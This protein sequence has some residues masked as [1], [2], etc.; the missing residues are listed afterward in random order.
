M[1]FT[2][3]PSGTLSESLKYEEV[4]DVCSKLK[5]GISGVDVDYEHIRYAG[6][7][8]WKLLFKLYQNFFTNSSVP[9]SVL[10]GVIL[11]LFKGKSAKANNK[12]NYR[13]ITLFPTLCKIYEMMLL[14]KLE[15]FAKDKGLFS[16]MQFGFKEGVGCTE[17]SFT[18]LEAIN[19]MI[20]RGSNVF[21]CFLDV[22]KAFDT[23]WIDGLLFKLFF[24]FGIRGRMWLALRSL[25]T[26]MK[27]HVLCFGSLSRKFDILQG[28]GQGRLLAPFMYKVYIN[29]LLTELTSHSCAL[30]LNNLSLSS[31]SFADDTSLLS[32]YPSF[33]NVFMQ[34]CYNYSLK[35]RYEFNH[36]KSGVV[37]FGETRLVHCIAMKERKWILGND[38]VN[39]LYEY[40][41]LGVVKNYIGSFSSN[42]EV[43]IDK[44]RKKAGMLFSA[45]FDRCKVNPLVYVKLWRQ[46]CLPS[47]LHG[48]ELF[49]ITQT[50]L[51]KFER[52]QQWFLKHVFYVPEFAPKRLLLKLSRLNSIESEIAL[53]KLLFLGRLITGQKMT[54]AL[55]RLFEL[56]SKSLFDANIISLGVLLSIC[57][58]LHKL[59]LFLYFDE[60]FQYSIFPTY[61]PWKL[62]VNRKIKDY[63]ENAWLSFVNDHPNFQIA[64][65]CLANLS[66]EKFWAITAEYPDLVCRLH[67]Q[68]RMMGW[69]GLNGGIPWL[70]NTDGALCFVCKSDIETLD[71]FLFNCPAFRQNFEMLWSS[72]NHKIKNCNPVDADNIIQFILNLDKSS[73]TMLLLGCLPL[74]FD[75]LTVSVIIR[76]ISSALG[77]I[78]KI[79]KN[80]L[81]ELE[82]PWL[83]L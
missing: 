46:A 25:Y 12:D 71:H 83:S 53:R 1:S 50:L 52:C 11:P 41:N 76:F 38:D 24:E 65:S 10:T 29:G 44:T 64:R 79:R 15:S 5:M 49:T 39:E 27:A 32:I 33:L 48:T 67:V 45:T 75:S 81:R 47:L 82:A 55:Q 35:W 4:E 80:K 26:G 2:D 56:R 9:E 51:E 36:S 30:S 62:I 59:D 66:P 68:I 72:L 18:I 63:E 28:T 69:L 70:L 6:P 78:Y 22:R 73:K 16:D 7:P 57:E 34:I 54:P 60:W 20:E 77:K 14:N 37:A 17:A 74:P 3:D 31:P 21:T 42:V 23:V 8:L 61:T 43:N 40:K 58:A 19:H 13:G